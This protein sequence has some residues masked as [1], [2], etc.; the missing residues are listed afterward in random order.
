MNTASP[1]LLIPE[2]ELRIAEA[3][4]AAYDLDGLGHSPEAVRKW[5]I[6][7]AKDPAAPCSSPTRLP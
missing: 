5:S 7:G 3:R 4:L 1:T 2:D 6:A